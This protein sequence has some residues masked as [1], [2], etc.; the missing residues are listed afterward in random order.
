V[1]YIAAR[2]P[3]P[4]PTLRV[5]ELLREWRAARRF[6][7]LALALQADISA[8]HLSC[9]ESG[10]AQPSRDMV[11]R[12]AQVLEL[13]LREENELLLAAG[14][15][16]EYRERT[17]TLPEMA[18]VLRAVELI[19]DHHEPYPAFVMNRHW[20]M[21]ST[22]HAF[23][24]VFNHIRATPSVHTNMMRQVF[25]PH[26]MRAAVE[27]WQEVAGDLI[28][29]LHNEV[30]ASPTDTKARAL[31][32]E[33]LAYPGVP[34]SWRVRPLESTTLPMLTSV[35][36]NGDLRLSFLSTFTTFG[37]SRDVTIDEIR[38]ESMFP[39]DAVTTEFC[40]SVAISKVDGEPGTSP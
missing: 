11:K 21:L 18:P 27:N 6:S 20:D 9:I 5:G 4:T 22:N 34:D 14:Y 8:R 30:S 3:P 36:R 38:I 10:K 15:A 7:Q 31:L 28:H 29:H 13:P 16:A 19:L 25:D 37:T 39:A 26:D 17:L 35:F 1:S 2:I 33:V 12:I 40:H 23:L 32:E 24:R